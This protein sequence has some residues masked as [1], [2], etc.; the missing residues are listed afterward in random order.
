MP[1]IDGKKVACWPCI[2]GHRSGTCNHAGSRIMMPV[3]RPGR[4]LS[5]CPHLPDTRCDC[6]T[7]SNNSSSSTAGGGT[8]Y[9]TPDSATLSSE[10]LSDLTAAPI[11]D[12]HSQ[13]MLYSTQTLSSQ[14]FTDPTLPLLSGMDYLP[15]DHLTSPYTT[16]MNTFPNWTILNSPESPHSPLDMNYVQPHHHSD[17]TASAHAPLYMDAQQ[18]ENWWSSSSHHIV[19]PYSSDIGAGTGTGTGGF[20]DAAFPQTHQ[21]MPQEEEQGQSLGRR[22]AIRRALT[23]AHG[24]RFLDQSNW[25]RLLPRAESKA[26]NHIHNQVMTHPG[27]ETHHNYERMSI[28]YFMYLTDDA[29]W[30][31]H[32]NGT[33][34]PFETIF[35]DEM[36]RRPFA[37]IVQEM[38][39]KVRANERASDDTYIRWPPV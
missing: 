4:P 9:E 17:H 2:R 32:G 13:N 20:I 26:L 33:T 30:E 22:A 19:D 6:R 39:A 36:Y 25:E 15:A 38:V 24:T 18:Q 14:V 21:D 37:P 31:P 1:I 16:N 35:I 8:H 29:L 3:R 10:T 27:G 12:Y 5:S 28:A 7:Q 34:P 11:H 23:E